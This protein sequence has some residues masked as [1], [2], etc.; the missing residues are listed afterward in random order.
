MANISQGNFLGS[1]PYGAR[2][3]LLQEMLVLAAPSFQLRFQ[4]RFQLGELIQHSHDLSL[5]L[6]WWDGYAD[7][8]KGFS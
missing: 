2:E 4:L 1:L 3:D 6:K 8:S 7:L 5:Y